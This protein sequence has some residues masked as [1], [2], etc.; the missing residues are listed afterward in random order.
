[1]SEHDEQA[2]FF[3]WVH[4]NRKFGKTTELRKALAL[5]YAV[6]NGGKRNKNIARK[7]QNEG[8]EAGMPDINLDYPVLTNPDS[9]LRL[10]Y[11]GWRCEMK[12]STKLTALQK[13]KKA[14]L[15]EAG[16]Q[17][18]ICYSADEAIKALMD[19]LPFPKNDYIK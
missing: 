4:L 11:P 10:E 8:L 17:Y 14:L 5:C 9:K 18:V 2:T 19:Y 7:M 15:E 12:F 6:P 3:A 13:E 1:M 16:F